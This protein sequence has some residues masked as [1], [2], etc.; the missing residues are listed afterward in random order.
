[1]LLLMVIALPGTN[2]DVSDLPALTTVGNDHTKDM[3]NLWPEPRPRQ[4]RVLNSYTPLTDS[5]IMTASQ[6]WVSDEA[7]AASTYGLV[8]TWNVAKVT[9][10]AT[11]WCGYDA[12]QCGSAYEAMRSFNGNISMWDVANVFTMF[13]SKSIRILENDLT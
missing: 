8:H 1:M 12:T 7:S 2:A 13:G 5:N 10:L 4:G 6:L 3:T 11:V 9:S